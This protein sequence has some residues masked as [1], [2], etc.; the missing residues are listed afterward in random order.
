[1]GKIITIIY[2]FLV[3]YVFY[4]IL[5]IANLSQ[6]SSSTFLEKSIAVLALVSI[7]WIVI[8]VSWLTIYKPVWKK[9]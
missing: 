5:M 9:Q 7:I 1:M 3:C 8:M 6:F 2:P 4:K